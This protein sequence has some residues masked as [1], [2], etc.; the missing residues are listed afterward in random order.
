MPLQHHAEVK[1]PRSYTGKY[2]YINTAKLLAISVA[3][4]AEKLLLVDLTFLC[5]QYT[6]LEMFFPMNFYC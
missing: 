1:W 3:V 5:V 6:N 2:K 4:F